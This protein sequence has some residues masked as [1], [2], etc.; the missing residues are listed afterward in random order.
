[1]EKTICIDGKNVRFKSTAGTLIR[2]RNQ[3]NRE[4]L[5]DLAKLQKAGPELTDNLTLAPIENMIWVLA[6]TADDSIPDP[7]TWYDSFDS[8]P[9]TDVFTKLEDLIGASLK[10]KNS[11][12]AVVNRRQR[13]KKRR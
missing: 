10:T 13:R 12:S 3:F 6:K 4:F 9:L 1:M 5:A 2:Y 7:L 8:F 11:S